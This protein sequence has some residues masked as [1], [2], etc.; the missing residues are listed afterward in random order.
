[1]TPLIKSL[2]RILLLLAVAFAVWCA[3]PFQR[4]MWKVQHAFAPVAEK[5]PNVH[6]Q[7]L[8]GGSAQSIH[9]GGAVTTAA[10]Q[11]AIVTTLAQTFPEA[12]AIQLCRD[13]QVATAPVATPAQTH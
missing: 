1:M 5:Y 7:F 4:R 10:E 3:L 13:I 2:L 6:V 9:L 12:E 11:Q 8:V